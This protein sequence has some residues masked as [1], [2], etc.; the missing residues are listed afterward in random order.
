MKY[1]GD[2]LWQFA[3]GA[4]ARCYVACKISPACNFARYNRTVVLNL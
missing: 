3:V 2:V 1:D 4:P